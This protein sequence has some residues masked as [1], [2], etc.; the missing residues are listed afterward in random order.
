MTGTIHNSAFNMTSNTI[1]WK[2]L[3]DLLE[4]PGATTVLWL[5]SY[6]QLYIQDPESWARFVFEERMANS[7]QVHFWNLHKDIFT[8][9]MQTSNP[10]LVTS[11]VIKK[12]NQY[13]SSRTGDG[14]LRTSSTVLRARRGQIQ[15]NLVFLLMRS[16]VMLC[17]CIHVSRRIIG[18]CFTLHLASKYW[19]GRGHLFTVV[20]SSTSS[21]AHVELPHSKSS[22][23]HSALT[24]DLHHKAIPL[25]YLQ[26][27][28]HI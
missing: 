13:L 1:T 25:P 28:H 20:M 15:G 11:D 8:P 12:F 7:T 24:K 16:F 10:L 18:P 2:E 17:A 26:K 5:V 4:R 14:V 6:L 3:D 23:E 22:F 21:K 19:C 27:V 9:Y